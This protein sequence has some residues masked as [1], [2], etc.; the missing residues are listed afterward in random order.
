MV[1]PVKILKFWWLSYFSFDFDQISIKMHWLTSSSISGTIH[2]NNAISFK[3]CG[4]TLFLTVLVAHLDRRLTGDQEVA[5]LIP[6]GS[7]NIDHEIFSLVILSLLLIQEGQLS[8]S[9]ERIYTGTGLQLRELSM[10][11]KSVVR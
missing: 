11:R 9:R 5:G 8:V 1:V 7:S 10:P 2:I 6:A 3:A 4:L